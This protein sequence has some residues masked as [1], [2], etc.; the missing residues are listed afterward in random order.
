MKC[1]HLHDDSQNVTTVPVMM[2]PITTRAYKRF[3]ALGKRVTST[4]CAIKASSKS[5]TRPLK[6]LISMRLIMKNKNST[7]FNNFL[8]AQR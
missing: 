4:W 5:R 3:S 8:F 7:A 1:N 2:I 6:L